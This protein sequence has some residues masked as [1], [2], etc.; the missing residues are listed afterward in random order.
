MLHNNKDKQMNNFE[1]V[2]ISSI[3][4]EIDELKFVIFLDYYEQKKWIK[5]DV[6]VYVKWSVL[7]NSK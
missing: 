5:K 1:I 7:K 6:A 3:Y 2:L 4:K